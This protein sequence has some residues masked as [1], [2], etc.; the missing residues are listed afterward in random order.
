MLLLVTNINFQTSYVSN[1]TFEPTELVKAYSD[2][3]VHLQSDL[4]VQSNA[5]I[6]RPY[7]PSNLT[8]LIKRKSQCLNS[9]VSY[10]Q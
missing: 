7:S 8:I 2:Q 3:N 9:P 4:L 10:T 5:L 6:Y 1:K